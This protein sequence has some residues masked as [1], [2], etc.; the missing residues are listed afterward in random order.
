MTLEPATVP[1]L[2]VFD[3]NETLSDMAPVAGRFAALGL[4]EHLAAPW[5][6][7]VL[8]DGMALTITG[9]NPSFADLARASFQAVVHGRPDAPADVDAAAGSVVETFMGL[10]LHP[11]VAPGLRELAGLGIRLV[12]LS[13][14]SAAVA[15]GLLERGGLGGVVERVLSV[16]DAPR[17]K[18][19]ASA[20]RYAL[21][22]CGTDATDAMLVAVH[23]WDIHGAASAGLRTAYVSRTGAP[24]P[25]T[26]RPPEMT[27]TSLTDLAA[28]F[29]G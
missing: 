15:D 3:V 7:G 13:N 12:T 29:D 22:T 6:A 5:F 2:L 14:G 1:R 8:R 24:Y 19:D 16:S 27:V 9:E 11:D 28:R 18:P 4:P 17:W 23:P 20:Y 10:P 26:M 25:S 21:D